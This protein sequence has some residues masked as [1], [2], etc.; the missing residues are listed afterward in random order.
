MEEI[1]ITYNTVSTHRQELRNKIQLIAASI[2]IIVGYSET[3]SIY[4]G[5]AIILPI[6][7]FVIAFLNVLFVKFYRKLAK[8]YD[9]RFEIL[10]VIMNGIIMLTTGIGY[11]LAGSKYIQFAYYILALLFLI[12]LPNIIL[13]IK[14]KRSLQFTRSKIIV[15][16]SLRKVTLMWQN[17]DWICIQKDILKIKQPGDRKIK[18]YFLDQDDRKQTQITDF[19]ENI[20]AESNYKFDIQKVGAS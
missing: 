11:H 2:G 14:M 17:I 1:R 16:K 8:T 18:I 12:I 9:H 10:I 15:K 7:G 6:I 19:I 13:P 4:K 20:K 3:F 5:I